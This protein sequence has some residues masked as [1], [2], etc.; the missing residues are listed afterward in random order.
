[1][2]FSPDVGEDEAGFAVVLVDEWSQGLDELSVSA[3]VNNRRVKRQPNSFFAVFAF[4]SILAAQ[5]I[6]GS[7]ILKVIAYSANVWFQL[8]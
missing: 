7:C 2:I 1:M 6:R 3:A 4:Y 8:F 5:A